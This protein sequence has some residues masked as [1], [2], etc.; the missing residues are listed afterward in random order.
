MNQTI[1][2]L[3]ALM[4]TTSMSF[5]QQS[6]TIFTY[7]KYID[8]ELEVMASSVALHVIE[9]TGAKAF[10]ERTKP[11]SMLTLGSPINSD[12]FSAAG[13]FGEATVC[14]LDQPYL[15]ASGCDDMDDVHMGAGIWQVVPFN[16]VAGTTLDFDVNVQVFYVDDT[17]MDT[18]LLGAK[19][20]HKKVIVTVRSPRHVKQQRYTDGFV[21]LSRV[22]PYSEVRALNRAGL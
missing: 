17:D 4:L 2:A 19:S 3:L 5:S 20:D 7:D 22:F 14:D 21:T 9:M 6:A 1:L 15:N 11:A 16:L 8:D 18:V 12:D 13:A 10:D